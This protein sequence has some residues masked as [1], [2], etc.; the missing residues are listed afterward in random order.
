VKGPALDKPTRARKQSGR[1]SGVRIVTR[2]VIWARGA[3]RCYFCNKELIGDF[4]AGLEDANFGFV[5]HIVAEIEGGPRGDPLLSPVL[6]D[7]PSNLMLAC[8]TH[9]KMIDV[10]RRDEFCIEAL[11]SIKRSHEDRI[12]TQASI[13]PD[14]ASHVLRYAAN[15]GAHLASMPYQDVARAMVPNCYPA[16]GRNTID[17]SMRG[18]VR[19]DDERT[20]WEN[21]ASNLKRLF[22]SRVRE[23]IQAGELHHLSVFAL[24]PQPLLMLLGALIGDITPAEVF[25]RHREPVGTWRWPDSG[26]A[27]PIVV[28]EPGRFEGPIS[29]KIALSA[30]VDDGRIYSVLGE[31]ASIWS[32]TT[33]SPHNDVL[34]RPDDLESFRRAMR[35]LFDRIKSVHRD[36]EIN[37]FPAMPVATAV[38]TGRVWMPKADLPLV[39]WD[40]NQA[41]G[42]FVPAISIGGAASN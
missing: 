39:V 5:A 34:K 4:L 30:T 11:Q 1:S 15:V 37:V 36:G 10:D 27:M 32:V 17:L 3:G 16:E 21:E 23:R 9:H 28:T 35:R 7:D 40:H 18:S 22:E 42:G 13:A 24:A 8:Y 12:T 26:D 19:T 33:P 29:L 41:L 2:C 31:K 25:Q 38:E 14:R 20:Y 6:A